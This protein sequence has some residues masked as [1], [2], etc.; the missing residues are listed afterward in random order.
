MLIAHNQRQFP[1]S[2]RCTPRSMPFVGRAVCELSRIV[3]MAG[4]RLH[5]QAYLLGLV[6]SIV[7]IG[8]AQSLGAGVSTATQVSAAPAWPN[9]SAG[10]F[11]RF[12]LAS[13]SIVG[14]P[15]ASDHIYGVSATWNATHRGLRG[16]QM[17]M[18]GVVAAVVEPASPRELEGMDT[19]CGA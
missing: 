3:I 18:K 9:V 6:C 15:G 10:W 13:A 8:R 7:R 11:Q 12:L 1:A 2:T 5:T 17:N 19:C 16:V 14:F 4:V